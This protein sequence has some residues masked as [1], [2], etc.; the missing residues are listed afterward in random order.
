MVLAELAVNSGG[1]HGACRICCGWEAQK[2]ARLDAL[3]LE[4]MVRAG[5]VVNAGGSMVLA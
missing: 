2:H 5:L 1:K 4:S 3:R